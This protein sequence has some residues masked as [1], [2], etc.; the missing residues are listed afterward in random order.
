MGAVDVSGVAVAGASTGLGVAGAVAGFEGW[1]GGRKSGPLYPQ[2][3]RT[4]QAI[5]VATIRKALR[6]RANWDTG[7]SMIRVG[8]CPEGEQLHRRAR[9]VLAGFINEFLTQN[10]RL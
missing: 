3:P 1:G 9:P 5:S 8:Y 2:A 4:P 10:T 7:D 6:L